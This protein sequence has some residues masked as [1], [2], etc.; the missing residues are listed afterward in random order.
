MTLISR[1]APAA[2]ITPAAR[3]QRETA[4]R[5]YFRTDVEGLRALAV[6]AVVAFH[7][8]VPGFAGGFV[9]VDIFFVISGY[10]ISGLLLREVQTTGRVS[11]TSFWAR[12]ARR[13]L[14]AATVVLL[15]TMIASALLEPLLG[16]YNTAQS[17]L[18]AGLYVANWHF[19]GIGTDY[20]AQGGA[21]S[22]VLHYWS[23]A[24]EEQFYLVWP[25]LVFGA[26]LVARKFPF[27]SSRIITLTFVAVTAASLAYSIVLTATD[28][29]LAYMS[30]FTRAWEFGLG[31][32]VASMGHWLQSKSTS[33]AYIRAGWVIGWAGVAAVV[34][35]IFTFTEAL[36]FPG[37][38]A[39]IPTL[40]TLAIII[41]GVLARP[42]SG[43]IG[44][45]LSLA[46]IRYIGRIS[47]SWYLWH[48]PILILV[49]AATG[50]LS[51]QLQSLLMVGALV[52]A[53]LTLHLVEMPITKW[54]Q[55][56][57]NVSGAI[58]LGLL[59]MVLSTSAALGVGSN[60]VANLSS[61]AAA[62]DVDSEAFA[63]VFGADTGA[64]SGQVTP[65]PIQA[66]HDGPV[67]K[68]CILDKEVGAVLA[69]TTGEKGG[70]PVVLFGDSHAHQWLTSVQEIA[71]NRNWEIF[72][73][74]KSGCPAADIAAR[75]GDPGRFSQPECPTWREASIDMIVNDIKPRL[76]LTSSLHTY[77]PDQGEIL[78]AW[79]ATLTDLR[80]VGAPI[81]YL[82]DTAHPTEDIPTCI[83]GAIDDWSKCA[84]KHDGIEEPVIQ[85]T[86][87]GN[88]PNVTVVDMLP[89]FCDGAE[90]PAVR[91]GLLLYRDSSHITATAALALA[92]ALEEALEEAK[93]AP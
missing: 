10:L 32:I 50:P 30:T 74:A 24:V 62:L 71:K 73:F 60:A 6:L 8:H 89:Y 49:Q 17:L 51:W 88:Q 64:N 45:L 59:C 15:A 12:R 61:D 67:P 75:P 16:V 25:L 1:E 53:A 93:V 70:T 83:S 27:V 18:A 90:C 41:G 9:G 13:I 11:L 23:L 91:N 28:P 14:P 47:F 52:L 92:P 78:D 77:V 82:R 48:W 57:K 40:G 85:Q 31:A 21:E 19:I 58:A 4:A 69:C 42:R 80:V 72:V 66:P 63:Q 5:N 3:E 87:L 65:N 84:F 86:L 29:T 39:L 37:S 34:I 35:S 76:I 56:A 68:D 2:V 43:S 79:D 22:P 7:A 26:Y 36:P 33:P 81:V 38:L 54:K 20:F 55:V 44:D 46:P